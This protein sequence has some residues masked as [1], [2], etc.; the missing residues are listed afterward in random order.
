MADR[1]HLY[2]RRQFVIG[3]KRFAPADGWQSLELTG[4]LIASV[5]PDLEFAV[6]RSEDRLLIALGF[7]VDPEHPESTSS[8]ILHTIAQHADCW[9]DVLNATDALTGRW[10]VIY[11]NRDEF[12]IFHDPYGLRQIYYVNGADGI[13]CGSQPEIIRANMPIGPSLDPRIRDFMNSP[14]YLNNEQPWFGERTPYEGCFHLLPNHYLDLNT[15]RAHRFFPGQPLAPVA[16]DDAV[17]TMATLLKGTFDALSRRGPLMLALTAGRDSRALLA[18]A[19]EHLSSVPC[20]MD[21]KGVLPHAHP[22]VQVPLRLARKLDF[23]FVVENSR[24]D[25]PQ[26]F[27]HTLDRNVTCARRLPK[28]RS[29]YAKLRREE[30]RLNV[31]GNGGEV[32]R[33]FLDPNGE[34]SDQDLTAEQI[35]SINKFS[36]HPFVTEELAAWLSDLEP[37]SGHIPFLDLCYWEQR[38]GN[39]G[40]HYP[41]E[42]D[43]AVEEVSPFNNRRI[44]TTMLSV[45]VEYR[46]PPDYLLH[47]ELIRRLWPEVLSEPFNPPVP[48]SLRRDGVAAIRSFVRRSL[49]DPVVGI[50]KRAIQRV[51]GR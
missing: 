15:G 20:Y 25:P 17:D 35:A 49:P 40:A 41:A 12:V 50:V 6:N 32:G 26:E 27:W 39:W 34:Y 37:C 29:V 5:H 16:L 11:K 8:E 2:Y 4:H 51:P 43:L 24:R 9:T 36:D 7:V 19:R 44:I 48:Y 30:T 13:W 42:Q 10:A 22:D 33:N 21:K 31:N 1:K 46:R 28:A 18:A 23:S 45:P 47:T 3:P 38:M 14:Q